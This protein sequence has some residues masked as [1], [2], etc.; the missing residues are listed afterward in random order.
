MEDWLEHYRI[1]MGL[2][3][4][5]LQNVRDG[6]AYS[7]ATRH[8]KSARQS[9]HQ[10]LIRKAILGVDDDMPPTKTRIPSAP[11]GIDSMQYFDMF[12]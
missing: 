1:A 5:Y 2:S 12:K 11:L 8:A 7:I 10:Q 6:P 4:P 9:D 3:S